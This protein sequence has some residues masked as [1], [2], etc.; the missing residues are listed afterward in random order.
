MEKKNILNV[1]ISFLLQGCIEPPG[2]GDYFEDFT[3]Q[4]FS[5]I[6]LLELVE[7]TLLRNH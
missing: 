3:L 6:R 4:L 5:M 1:N 2:G 7:I